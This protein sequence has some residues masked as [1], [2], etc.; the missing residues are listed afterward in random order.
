MHAITVTGYGNP[1]DVLR[2][3][4]L[5]VPTVAAD[6]VLVRVDAASINPADWHLIRGIPR[7]A[8]LS[9]GVRR[10]GFQIP[11][12]D[13]AGTVEAIGPSVTTVRPGDIVFG[14]TFMAGFGALAELVVVPERL[15]AIRP[16]NVA[17]ED[18]AAVPLAGSTALQALRDHGHVDPGDKVLI[19]GASGGVGAYAVQIAKHLGA[20][21]TAVASE[22]NLDFVRS[23]G[24][25]H[26]VDYTA[27]DI[28]QQLDR[29][30]LVVQL[31]GTHPA[32]QLRRLLAPAGTL[33]QLSGDSANRW[34]GPMGRV[35]RG[36]LGAIR[37]VQTVTAF[38]VQ[39]DHD[40]LVVL[41]DLLES[42]VLRTH[43]D[44]TVD[45]ADV[46]AAIERVESGHT[47][48]KLVVR[49]GAASSDRGPSIPDGNLRSRS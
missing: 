18:A 45:L 48:G 20:E 26:V 43:L 35:I 47:R 9:I 25:D 38:T 22:A 42:G 7:I 4:D 34:F 30:D 39:P 27:S 6:Q 37:G 33:L 5:P 12:S 44:R 13:V 28:T 41:A 40:G 14:T 2:P 19:I 46:V 21:V 3:A 11:G 8:R 16:R 10:P 24:A 17:A 49:V 15:L 23:L 1:A 29:F 31:A 32:S 36:R